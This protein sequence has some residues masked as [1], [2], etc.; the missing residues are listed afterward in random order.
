MENPINLKKIALAVLGA[1]LSI[2]LLSACTPQK[3]LSRLI[4][5]FPHLVQNDTIIAR[6]TVEVVVPSVELDTLFSVKELH[7]TVTIEKD[8]LVY[9]TWIVNDTVYVSAKCDTVKIRVP[10]EI[11]VEV[12]KVCPQEENTLQWWFF[13]G[14]GLLL[15]II[16]IALLARRKRD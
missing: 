15:L 6:D 9:R 3:R 16:I 5:K 2:A 14:A 10:V 8:N 7:D 4:T 13:A 12:E 11:P 1:L